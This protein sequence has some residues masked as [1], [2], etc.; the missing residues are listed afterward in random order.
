[1]PTDEQRQINTAAPVTLADGTYSGIRYGYTLELNTEKIETEDGVRNTREHAAAPRQ[2]RVRGGSVY[3]LCKQAEITLDISKGDVL[4]GGRFKNM[5]TVVEEIG[6]D[7]LG[8]PTINGKKL[9][10]FRIAKKMPPKTASAGQTFTKSEILEL[11]RQYSRPDVGIGAG[12]AMVLHGLRDST[13]DI[14]ADAPTGTFNALLAQHNSPEVRK[15]IL[16]S[17][18]FTIPGTPI[19]LHEQAEGD[20]TERE[21]LPDVVGQVETRKSL[22]DFYRRLNREKDQPW[23]AKLQEK[24]AQAFSEGE[25]IDYFLQHH[26][27]PGMPGRSHADLRLGRP[28]EPLQSWAI[29]KKRL[30][31]PGEKLLAPETVPHDYGYGRFSGKFGKGRNASEVSLLES[32][33][34]TVGGVKDGV[35]TFSVKNGDKTR[36]FALVRIADKKK[37]LII[38]QNDAK[39]PVPAADNEI[40]AKIASG[41]VK[42]VEVPLKLVSSTGDTKAEVLAE[43]ADTP[44]TRRSGLSKRAELPDGRGMFFDVPGPFWMKDVNIPLD[45]IFMSKTGSVLDF[46]TMEAEDP[47]TQKDPCTKTGDNADTSPVT[48]KQSGLKLYKSAYPEAAYA[49]EVPAGWAARHAV[50]RGDYLEVRNM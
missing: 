38:G 12:S 11:L 48:C 40:P 50:E 43:V 4:L 41:M 44:E 33:Q 30:P 35:F 20:N 32:G 13:H 31:E 27:K 29:P 10:S 7:E 2:Y 45:V 17:R 24:E 22:L 18:V 49:L 42:N 21:A 46:C 6:T 47:C 25:I 23:I 34:S 19:D 28:G 16:G 37:W 14:D 9:L 3:E 36:K 1:M 39:K 15:S 26:H 8:Q 5:K